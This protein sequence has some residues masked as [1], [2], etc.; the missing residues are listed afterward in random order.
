MYHELLATPDTCRW[1]YFDS[2]AK[3]VLTVESGDVV[4]VQCVSH[5]AGDAPDLMM[6][7]GVRAIYDGLDP[8]DRGPGKHIVT[9]PIAVVG[10]EPGDVLEC[11]LLQAEPRLP[12][13]VNFEAPWGLLHDPAHA[14]PDGGATD[15]EGREHVVVYEADWERGVARGVFQYAYPRAERPGY[16]G[17]VVDPRAVQREPALNDV[18]VPLRPHMGIAGVAP[19]RPG[20]TDTVPPGTFGGNVD[21]RSFVA[22]TRMSYPVHVAGA[23]FYAGDTHFAEGDGEISGTAIEGHL[24]VLLQLV[25]HKQTGIRTPV[26]ETPTALMVHGFHTSLDEAVRIAATETIH[27]MR[28]R[29]VV[30]PQEAYSLLSVS[31]DLRVTQV[32][33]RVKGAHVVL[34][35]D[36]VRGLARRVGAVH[37]QGG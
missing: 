19:A 17:A 3:P 20:R 24:D 33:N 27:E 23:L 28:R 12:Y 1:G 7:E 15:L 16:P 6:D 37:P 10:A 14:S 21:N 4:A 18:A 25:L 22:G 36:V 8:A 34:G 29:W 26:L 32:V 31:G 11:R 13:G 35:K 5:R 9:G 30:S 2:A